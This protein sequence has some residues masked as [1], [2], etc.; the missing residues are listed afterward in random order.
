MSNK[1]HPI[2]KERHIVSTADGSSSIYIPA[3]DESYHSKFGSIAEAQHI[4]IENGLQPVAGKKDEINIFEMGLGTGLNVLLTYIFNEETKLKINYTS[5]EKYPLKPAEVS[6]LNFLQI[7]HREELNSVFKQIH[8][9]AWGEYMEIS[10]GF[11]LNKVKADIEDYHF[12]QSIDLVYYDAFAPDV[13]PDLWTTEIFERIYRAMGND[14]VLM[15]YCVKG[16]IRRTL[17]DIGFGVQKLKGPAGGKR[18][19]LQ[20]VKK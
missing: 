14:A 8:S 6:T 15:T 18:E 10:T 5:I 11:T 4:Y 20:A 13:Q 3:L 17:K 2:A 1:N 12:D 7:L 9:E 19:I 16:M